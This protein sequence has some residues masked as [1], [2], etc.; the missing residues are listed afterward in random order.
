[1]VRNYKRKTDF[2]NTPQHVYDKAVKEVMDGV[3]TLRGAAKKY[4]INVMTL[5]RCK[6]KK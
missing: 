5:Q 6:K 1:M 2:G 3:M 4:N